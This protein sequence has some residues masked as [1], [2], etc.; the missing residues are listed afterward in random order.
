MRRIES[1]EGRPLEALG[2]DAAEERIYRHLVHRPGA[3]ARDI[4]AEL[5]VPLRRVQRLLE[6]IERK[7][8]ARHSP[9]HPRRYHAA[10]PDMAIEAL[11]L[12][13]QEDLQRARVVAQELQEQAAA[14]RVAGSP[15]QMVELVAS[16][17]GE[18]LVFEQLYLGA[19]VEL[20]TLMRPPMRVSSMQPPFDLPL[21]RQAHERGVRF[22]TLVDD[23]YLGLPGGLAYLAAEMDGGVQARRVAHLPF[24]LVMADRRIAI[25]PL[26]LEQSDNH[27]L[28]VRSSALLDAL[29]ALFEILWERGN[30]VALSERGLPVAFAGASTGESQA[31]QQAL[32]GLMA[33]GLNDKAIAHELGISARTLERRLAELMRGLGARTRFQAGYLAAQARDR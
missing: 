18:R 33:M 28:V 19:Q 2:I 9:E 14:A 32:L 21:Q 7:G 31:D 17:T 26:R 1:G 23:D 11:I 10:A 5:E 27:I 25:I 29:Y 12:K 16:S 24:K 3:I 6:A 22:R 30:P 4:A 20:V 15:E 8:L 13:Q